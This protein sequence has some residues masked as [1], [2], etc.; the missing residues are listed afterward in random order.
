MI[1][2]TLALTGDSLEL[3]CPDAKLDLTR[4]LG[5]PPFAAWSA[6]Y[7]RALH[8]SAPLADAL[9]A[10]GDDIRAWLDGGE[11]WMSRLLASASP[12]LVLE[13]LVDT[14]RP[15]DGQLAFL[16]APWELMTQGSTH[17][18]TR[19]DVLLCPVRR[20]GRPREPMP[21][22]P[23]RLSVVFMAAAPRGASELFF[24]HEEAAILDAA[25]AAGLD[26]TVEESGTLKW[27]ADCMA[28]QKPVD[29]LQISS[30]GT[31]EPSPLLL[32]ETELGDRHPASAEDIASE[33]GANLPER[34]AFVSACSTADPCAV[35]GSLAAGL[36]RHGCPATLGWGGAVLDS[37]ATDFAAALYKHL[38][39]RASLEEAVARARGDLVQS[40]LDNDGARPSR[41]WHLVRLYLGASG[42]GQ[43]T[44]GT[45]ARGRK[46]QSAGYK[47]FL[48]ARRLLVPVASREEF[49]G[50]RRELQT[51]LRE[52]RMPEHAGVLIHG[53]GRH[54]KSSLAARVAHRMPEHALALVFERYDARAVL[55]AIARAA[56]TREVQDCI[57]GWRDKVR[58]RPE[59]LAIALRELLEGPCRERVENEHGDVVRRPILLII[60]DFERVL[61]EPSDNGW[62]AVK[63]AYLPVVCAVIEA[64]GEADTDSRLLITSRYHFRAFAGGRDRAEVLLPVQL[65]PMREVEGRKQAAAKQRVVRGADLDAGRLHRCIESA[66][67]NPGLQDLLFRSAIEAPE[68]CDQALAAM[69]AYLKDGH[70]PTQEHVRDFIENLAIDRLLGCLRS[71]ERA[72]LDASELF[73]LPVPREVLQRLGAAVGAGE[74]AAG[75]LVALGLWDTYSDLVTPAVDAMLVNPLV[76]PRLRALADAEARALAASILPL[77]YEAWGG[78]DE[79]RE[80]MVEHE[81]TRLALYAQEAAIAARTATAALRWLDGMEEYGAAAALGQAVLELLDST[82]VE[83]SLAL[84]RA[85][86]EANHRVGETAQAREIFE[87][88]LAAADVTGGEEDAFECAA[89][90]GAHA[91]LL[92]QL[93]H[94]DDALA[95]FERTRDAFEELGDRRSRA[96]TLG[97]IARILESTGK[98]EQALAL[99]EEILKDFEELGDRRS[100][101]VV[102]GEI[103]RILESKRKV[104]EALALY[105]EML[106]VFEELGDRRSRAATLGNIAWILGSKG[107]VEQV[108]LALALYQKNLKDYE[109]LEDIVGTAQTYWSIAQ[110][111]LER[112]DFQDAFAHLAESY[113]INVQIKHLDGICHVGSALGQLL[114]A[115]GQV[116]QGTAVLQRSIEGFRQLGQTEMARQLEDILELSR[117]S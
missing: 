33:L 112:G 46:Q 4:P 95:A 1:R 11:G 76:L 31:T 26:L 20:L 23:Y 114:L 7:R 88:A 89:I 49:V 54:G 86:G 55:D 14:I 111:E 22:S 91:R 5:P 24:E 115:G 3:R 29:V 73:S 103:A 21:P 85:A 36:I 50:R 109:E 9:R 70:A 65:G 17:L 51:I 72:L 42:G 92:V 63:P 27:L 40:R 43:L 71:G 84:L 60:D 99:Y 108:E 16:E 80:G 19:S 6:R 100:R 66:C 67:G 8:D 77:L 32:L 81:L 41:D 28:Q 94:V 75:R 74:G 87:R 93:G 10:I 30:H 116:G 62:P 69:Q 59:A 25:G 37:E 15:D 68:V 56:G 90:L 34:L 13:L 45:R 52:L 83:P 35:I 53:L 79:G 57:D 117:S 64:F 105:K 61:D 106:K 18:A 47:A 98:V 102:L 107:Q 39:R 78:D 2:A 58:E 101:A 48:D 113:R 96:V 38:N 97:E 82:K 110:L 12:P 44:R 104:K